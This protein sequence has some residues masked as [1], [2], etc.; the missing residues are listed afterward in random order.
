M[1]KT[2][3]HVRNVRHKHSRDTERGHQTFLADLGNKSLTLV[4]ESD[5][6]FYGC[7]YP[8]DLRCWTLTVIKDL[9]GT[10][11]PNSLSP[12]T[13]IK[14]RDLPR[15]AKMEARFLKNCFRKVRNQRTVRETLQGG[16]G[17]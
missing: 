6:T 1:T 11:V 13:K 5:R 2:S 8:K 17:F 3:Q 12:S 15:S 4:F 16:R 7:V 10:V 14:D 9:L